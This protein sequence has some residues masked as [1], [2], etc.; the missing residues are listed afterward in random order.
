MRET[1]GSTLLNPAETNSQDD[2]LP[3]A[4]AQPTDVAPE[5]VAIR[6]S[7]QSGNDEAT[8]KTV[9]KMMETRHDN[10]FAD[11]KEEHAVTVAELKEEI[12]CL[13]GKLTAA[14]QH[15][16]KTQKRVTRLLRGQTGLMAQVNGSK[17]A[18]QEAISAS[19]TLQAQHDELKEKYEEVLLAHENT[20]QPS[21]TQS[22]DETINTECPVH[23]HKVLEQELAQTNRAFQEMGADLS[24][25]LD[26]NRL[27]S[28]EV[29][30]LKQAL[31]QHPEHDIG[32]QKVIEYKDHML[33]TLETRAGQC[34]S[35]YNKLQ[36]KST[37]DKD[38]ADEE[39]S[40][41][42]AQLTEKNSLISQ[43]RSSVEEHK[44]TSD[45]V[46][47]TLQENG[48]SNDLIKSIEIVFQ[49]RRSEDYILTVGIKKLEGE[50]DEM[51]GEMGR[52]RADLLEAKRSSDEKDDLCKDLQQ[53]VREKEAELGNL[54]M[55]ND[56]L[57]HDTEKVVEE[58]ERSLA[59]AEKRN[60]AVTEHLEKVM[61]G[62]VGEAA[63]EYIHRQ[64]HEKD[65]FRTL[66]EHVCEENYN[67][68]QL[69]AERE[70]QTNFALCQVYYNGVRHENVEGRLKEAEKEIETLR[71]EIHRL[72]HL[73]HVI[74]ISKVLKVQAEFEA[75]RE[76]ISRLA[77]I[78]R[79]EDW[80]NGNGSYQTAVECISKLKKAGHN[81]LIMLDRFNTANQAGEPGGDFDEVNTY[82]EGSR[83]LLDGIPSCVPDEEDIYHDRWMPEETEEE[84]EPEL[85]GEEVTKGSGEFDT[86]LF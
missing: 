79:E 47:T 29:Y 78:I 53:A 69:A 60:E 57:Q 12:E 64:R 25:A 26:E 63:Q 77:R 19:Q 80:K 34:L 36:K 44:K 86:S 41:L 27:R 1:S 45:G 32:L 16:E 20:P 37:E 50:I 42:N 28:N 15:K 73:P 11:L 49:A 3:Q 8:W 17:A 22:G 70:G 39:I 58:K 21:S 38:L 23:E 68:R 14:D 10:D 83:E 76:E 72:E 2:S 74:H 18:L 48:D 84:Q 52:L 71:E 66:H 33:Q 43:L 81:L 31:E 51:H 4:T 24:K 67:L 6:L 40:R 46:L 30:Q 59:E 54:Q 5:D 61:S 82:I 55:E 35:D 65:Y 75:A 7:S 13:Q 62:T 9:V 56:I 85:P